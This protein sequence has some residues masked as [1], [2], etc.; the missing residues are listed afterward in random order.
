MK[1]KYRVYDKKKKTYLSEFKYYI[2][3]EGDLYLCT[4]WY[5]EKKP[6]G[7]ELADPERFVVEWL[8]IEYNNQEIYQGD[9]VQW[10]GYEV[11]GG[12]QIRPKRNFLV[13]DLIKDG[14]KLSCLLSQC[15]PLEII[16][17]IHKNPELLQKGIK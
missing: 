6:Y 16:N 10:L 14:Y 1:R 15:I 12:K 17:N 7:F 3:C 13:R 9:I 11:R 2:D 8:V 4:E 5:G